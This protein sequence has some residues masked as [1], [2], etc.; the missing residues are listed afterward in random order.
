VLVTLAVQ[1][2][3]SLSDVVVPLRRLN[4]VTGANGTGKSNLYRALRLLADVARGG[5][6]AALAREGGLPSTLWAGQREPGGPTQTALRLGFATEDLGYAIDLGVPAQRQSAFALDPEIKR[7]CVW[8]GPLLRPSTLQA[9]RSAGSVR[10]RDDD[11]AWHP[12][13]RFLAPYD[14]MLSEVVDPRRAPELLAFREAVR[15]WRF[16]DHFRTDATAPARAT[17]VG[18]RTMVLGPDGT[19]LAAALQTIYE[20]GDAGALDDAVDQ[21]FPGSRIEVTADAG[22]FDLALHQPGL[23]RPLHAAELSDGTLRYLLWMAALLSPR[24][25]E[26]LVLNEPES[27]LHP[28]LLP[29]LAG[30]IAGATARTQVIA[31]THSGALTRALATAAADALPAD[32]HQ[33]LE[34][35]KQNGRTVVVGQERFDRPHW[36]WPER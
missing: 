15:S 26:A 30:L 9:D 31:V 11:G 20:I 29:A 27:S 3:R 21:A 34:L 33:T 7:E 36:Q 24:P 32:Q 25:P 4:V 28:D 13:G 14:S 10:L 35:A 23:L 1:N 16:Y 17:Q 5:A 22:R 19:D 18:T 12:L 8:A 2:Y 6:V